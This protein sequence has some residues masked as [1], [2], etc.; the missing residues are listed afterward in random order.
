MLI[1]CTLV[2]G[3]LTVSLTGIYVGLVIGLQALL[4]GI[5][6]QGSSVAIV[7]STLA[8]AALFQPLRRRIQ[9]VIDRRFYRRKYDAARV[10]AAFSATLRREVDLDQLRE[11]LLAVVQ[12]TMQPAH[13]SLWLRPPE[14]ASTKQATWSS[15]PPAPQDVEEQ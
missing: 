11:H 3:T 8:I 1:N 5:I 4:R 2:Y 9:Q 6:N 14:Q 10:V 15:T 7:I 13:V 12:E